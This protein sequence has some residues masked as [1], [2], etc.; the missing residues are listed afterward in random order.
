MGKMLIVLVN[1]TIHNID[2]FTNI[3]HFTCHIVATLPTSIYIET[4]AR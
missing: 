1:S 4:G 3:N 2:D